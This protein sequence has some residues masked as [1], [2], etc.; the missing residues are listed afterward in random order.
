[1]GYLY[2]MEKNIAKLLLD[3]INDKNINKIIFMS[4]VESLAE[5]EALKEETEQFEEI[6]RGVV[7]GYN[8]EEIEIIESQ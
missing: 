8:K 1:M 5:I 6:S 3:K 2:H 7:K 4:D